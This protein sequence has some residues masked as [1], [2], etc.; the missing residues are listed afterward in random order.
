M[1]AIDAAALGSCVKW[2]HGLDEKD[3]P[4]LYFLQLPIPYIVYVPKVMKVGWQ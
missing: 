3:G 4:K 2:A 1:G